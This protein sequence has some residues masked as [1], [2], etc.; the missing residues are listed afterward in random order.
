MAA[1]WVDQIVALIV[2]QQP[3]GY[4]VKVCNAGPGTATWTGL[5]RALP[6]KHGSAIRFLPCLSGRR[7]G[8]APD[9]TSRPR[10]RRTDR[11]SRPRRRWTVLGRAA[12]KWAQVT[13]EW[14]SSRSNRSNIAAE[15]VPSCDRT[16]A[17]AGPLSQPTRP[18]IAGSFPQSRFDCLAVGP[19]SLVKL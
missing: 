8:T 4:L 18:P 6:G 10:R 16:R 11:T 12:L 5:F 17:Q 15:P 7:T 9:R 14:R 3:A 13:K 1:T 19:L 2:C